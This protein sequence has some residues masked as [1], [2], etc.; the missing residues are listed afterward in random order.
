M[1]NLHNINVLL[2]EC[3]NYLKWNWNID[4]QLDFSLINLQVNRYKLAET[5]KQVSQDFTFIK[6]E[7]IWGD[8]IREQ[9]AR[10]SDDLF[11]E[12]YDK[13]IKDLKGL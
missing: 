9:C 4:L 13:I 5:W 1:K 2:M 6:D 8:S 10:V 12:N 7:T 11:N 3:D